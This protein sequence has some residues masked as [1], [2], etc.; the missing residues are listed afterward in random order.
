MKLRWMPAAQAALVEIE[1]YLAGQGSAVRARSEI[2]R[3]IVAAEKLRQ[4]PRM[5]RKV[6]PENR[7]ELRVIG[8]RPYWLYYRIRSD[9]IEVLLVW[10]Y[11]KEPPRTL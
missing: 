4:V 3:L 8:V 7:D 5:G 6:Q 1:A 10:H 2:E 9:A 11:R